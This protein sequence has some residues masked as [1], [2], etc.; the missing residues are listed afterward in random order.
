[1]NQ[2]GDAT[3]VA[4]TTLPNKA[5]RG[6]MYLV[7]CITLSPALSPLLAAQAYAPP[8]SQSRFEKEKRL[9]LNILKDQAAIW[10]SP[11]HMQLKPMLFVGAMGVASAI[12]AVNDN[13]IIETLGQD[14]NR[15]RISGYVSHVGT[16][17]VN[18]GVAGG[19]WA[20]GRLTKNSYLADTGLLTL[21]ALTDTTIITGIAKVA[22]DRKRPIDGGDGSFLNGGHS[23]FSGHSS[24][25]WTT[26]TV[27]ASRYPHKP[28]VKYPAF[29]LATAAS[30][31]R[32]TARK[33]FAS[34]VLVGT[35]VGILIGRY[36][37][38][39]RGDELS[40][41]VSFMPISNLRTQ[42]FGVRISF[43]GF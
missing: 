31:S 22:A 11:L 6:A 20:I 25:S 38:R 36:V 3:R 14:A 7:L 23:F 17:P 9:P 18:F 10:T 24:L 2:N 40:S 33:H 32:I 13:D 16:L 35:T 1:M 28:W 5:L 39:K 12:V 41:H 21:E 19:T 27:L 15:E 43:T 29:V 37:A 42:T 34:D 30:V 8:A 26:A 4:V